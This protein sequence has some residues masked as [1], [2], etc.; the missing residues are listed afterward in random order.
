MESPSGM[1]IGTEV[2]STETSGH[3]AN[4]RPSLSQLLEQRTALTQSNVTCVGFSNSFFALIESKMLMFGSMS[5]RKSGASSTS[6]QTS[7]SALKGAR[8]KEDTDQGAMGPDHHNSNVTSRETSPHQSPSSQQNTRDRFSLH[9]GVQVMPLLGNQTKL[10][11][12][13]CYT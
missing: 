5:G 3:R 7:E 9:F 6:D 8:P 10:L 12:L 2:S 4:D 1:S 11:V 13:P